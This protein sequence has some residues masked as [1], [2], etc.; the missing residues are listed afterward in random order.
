MEDLLPHENIKFIC[1]NKQKIIGLLNGADY[2]IWHPKTSPYLTRKY[3]INSRGN[4]LYY[5]KNIFK[6]CGF[7]SR[8]IE[9][10]PLI[11]YMCRL[12]EQKGINLFLDAYDKNQKAAIFFFKKFLDLGCKFIIYGTPS[13]G[14]KGEIHK[15]FTKISNEFRDSCYYSSEYNDK[16]AHHFLAAADIVL[17]PSLFEPCG[18]VQMYSMAF[19]AIPIVWPIGGLKDTVTCFFE[20]G[21]ISTGFYMD[22]FS[23][24]S[25]YSTTKRAVEIFKDH[26]DIWEQIQTNAMEQDFSWGNN[27]KHYF[28]FIEEHTPEY[29]FLD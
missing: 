13:A 21:N 5:K 7:K 4:K 23:R 24:E 14:I 8:D 3:D 1:S 20:K 15:S 10:I 26:P 22:T 6:K 25:L 27:I 18:L 29:H 16:N 12:T 9:N 2:S 11:L 28:N 17:L 19:G